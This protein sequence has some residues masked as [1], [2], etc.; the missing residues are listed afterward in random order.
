MESHSKYSFEERNGI[1]VKQYASGYTRKYN[2]K[3]GGMV[4]RRMR[5]AI[6]AVASFWL[7]AWIN[8]GQPDHSVLMNESQSETERLELD[9]LGAQWQRAGS[10]IGREEAP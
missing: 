2:E 7:T 3:L 1:I 9:S 5:Q 8:A 4:E 10:I 6:Y